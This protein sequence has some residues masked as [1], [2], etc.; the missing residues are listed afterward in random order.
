MNLV[1][2]ESITI[3]TT[4]QR[5]AIDPES[6]MELTNS[7]AEVGLIHPI[8]VRTE[9]DL[10]ILVAGERRLKAIQTIWAMGGFFTHEREAVPEG[11]IPCTWLKDLDPLTAMAVEL[12]ENIKRQDLS[13]QDRSQ[14]TS[15]LFELRRL[16]A[17]KAGRAAPQPVE[18]AKTLYPEHHPDAA[19]NAVREELI[20]ARHLKDPDVAKA[21]SAREGMKVIRRKEE[22]QRQVILGQQVGRTFGAHSHELYQGNCLDIMKD[23]PDGLFDVILTDPPYGI[24]AQD[25]NDSGGKANATGH[26]YDDSLDNWRVL[27]TAFASHSYRITKPQSH[28]YVFCDIDN[29]LELRSI[30]AGAGWKTF[31]TPLVWH[32]PTSQRA[33]WP[34]SGPHRRYQLCLYAIKGDRPVLK[35]APDLVTYAS[36][37]NLGWAAQK[38]VGLYSDLLVRSCR[39]G[40]SVLDPFAG[41]GTIF[42]AAHGL[43]IRATGI[44][45]DPV[46]YGIAVKRIGE[47]K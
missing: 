3:L 37:E 26:T 32:N 10:I 27:I 28:C 15:E 20:L 7:I 24:D 17:E 41:S 29:F 22:A 33:P 42:P 34:N 5:K 4:R 12:E 40:D 45:T 2:A 46:A 44:E 16:Q 23:I 43:K 47:L 13:W 9:D 38:P 1:R 30:M 11:Q 18:F 8:V 14:A 6:L 36:D 19:S 35:L 21:P 31:R 39:A 25:F